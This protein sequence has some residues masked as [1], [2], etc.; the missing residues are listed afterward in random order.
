MP[1]IAVVVNAENPR[2]P[3]GGVQRWGAFGAAKKVAMIDARPATRSIGCDV[4]L[5]R[6]VTRLGASRQVTALD[7]GA[8]A[9]GGEDDTGQV[10]GFVRG[11]EGDDL[12]DL[13]DLGAPSEQ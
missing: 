12:G 1:N 11:E 2:R 13:V 3:L 6:R 4:A 9:V 7:G 8:A 5:G 10:A